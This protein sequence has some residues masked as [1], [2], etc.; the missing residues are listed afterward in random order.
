MIGVEE[1]GAE[2]AA[3]VELAVGVEAAGAAEMSSRQDA[4]ALEQNARVYH[5]LDG[6]WCGR[7]DGGGGG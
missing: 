5:V 1:E 7:R 4:G 2:L 3:E 6:G